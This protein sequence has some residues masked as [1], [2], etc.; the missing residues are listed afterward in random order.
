MGLP[1]VAPSLRLLSTLHTAFGFMGHKGP[2]NVPWRATPEQPLRTFLTQGSGG[3]WYAPRAPA[4]G[5]GCC[6]RDP[7]DA[8]DASAS[9]AW[10][11]FADFYAWPH[12]LYYESPQQLLVRHVTAM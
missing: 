5:A 9:A 8:C 12:V 6:A 10:L 1:I 7:N 11:Q 3:M 2:G 4:S